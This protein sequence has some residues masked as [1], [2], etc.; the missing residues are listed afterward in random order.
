MPLSRPRQASAR[1]EKRYA[2]WPPHAKSA[3]GAF[4]GVVLDR[5]SPGLSARP[6]PC[7]GPGACV[8]VAACCSLGRARWGPF[9]LPRSSFWP[10]ENG[11]PDSPRPRAGGCRY[12]GVER[13]GGRKLKKAARLTWPVP[14]VGPFAARRRGGCRCVCALGRKSKPPF[15]P[16]P[17]AK[18]AGGPLKK[19]RPGGRGGAL[20][21]S[22]LRNKI[23]GIEHA[24]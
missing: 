11:G 15:S 2:A 23:L 19:A 10:P 24:F 14:P 12:S 16:A 8:V 20:A 4:G 5:N 1:D 3:P 13:P 7:S 22:R 17:R 9:G 18:R 21:W 6:P